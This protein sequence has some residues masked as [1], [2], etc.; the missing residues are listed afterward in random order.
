MLNYR[1][2]GT[3]LTAW[4]MVLTEMAVATVGNIPKILENLR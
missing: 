3:L 2:S 1:N 4:S